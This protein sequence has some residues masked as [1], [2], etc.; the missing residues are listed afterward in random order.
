VYDQI[1]LHLGYSLREYSQSAAGAHAKKTN[2]TFRFLLHATNSWMTDGKVGSGVI[3]Q[4]PAVSSAASGLP[5]ARLLCS[6]TAWE[7]R[8]LDAA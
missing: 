8:V 5:G 6:S 1:R 3:E 2:A 7:L 4:R